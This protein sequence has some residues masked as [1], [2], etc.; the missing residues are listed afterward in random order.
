M[1]RLIRKDL[2]YACGTYSICGDGNHVVYM[3]YDNFREEW[4][5][6]ELNHLIRRYRLSHFYIFT[7]S[8]KSS[9][10]KFHAVCF[11]KLSARQYNDLIMSSN[12]D[13]LF[14]NNSFFDL[15]NARVLRFSVK[16]ASQINRPR[17]HKIILSPHHKRKKSYAHILFYKRMFGIEI[18]DKNHDER[19]DIGLLKYATVKR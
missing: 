4:L 6:D 10:K 17:F 2:S 16:T 7:S 12:A 18:D 13:V 11:D 5:I 15:Q 9:R 1:M 14:R 3:D 8:Q 19:K